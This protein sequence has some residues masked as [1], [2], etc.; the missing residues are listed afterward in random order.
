MSAL[1]LSDIFARVRVVLEAPPL[2]L[3]PTTDAFSHARQ[4]TTLL[5]NSYYLEDGGLVSSQSV[6]N[7]DAVREDRV[8]I[9]VAQKLA[10]DGAAALDTLEDTLVAVERALVA[11]GPAQSYSVGPR[12]E[13]RITRADGADVAV[14]SIALTVNYDFD[15]V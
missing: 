7:Y 9:Y 10:F 11:D 15:E 13:R 12:P 8:T 1:T 4:P 2:T 5:T 3:T 14:G 6:G